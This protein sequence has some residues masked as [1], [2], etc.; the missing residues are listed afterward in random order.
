[1]S[2]YFLLALWELLKVVHSS[3]RCWAK[4]RDCHFMADEEFEGK[5]GSSQM[6]VSESSKFSLDGCSLL[7]VMR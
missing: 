5:V 1:M 4:V 3:K 2:R 6:V 7:L